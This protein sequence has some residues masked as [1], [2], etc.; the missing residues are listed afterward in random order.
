MDHLIEKPRAFKIFVVFV[1]HQ[2]CPSHS[3]SVPSM[4]QPYALRNTWHHMGQ[5]KYNI[6]IIRRGQILDFM[7]ISIVKINCGKIISTQFPRLCQFPCIDIIQ[8][9]RW[10]NWVD[11][12]TLRRSSMSRQPQVKRTIKGFSHIHSRFGRSRSCMSKRNIR[13]IREIHC[14]TNVNLKVI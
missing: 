4:E 12:W 1:V 13:C 9:W 10:W 7:N 8:A 5:H 3:L 6:T 2:G 14:R 11:M